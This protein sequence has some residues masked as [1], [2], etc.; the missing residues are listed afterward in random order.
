MFRI[1]TTHEFTVN[2]NVNVN[3]SG[4]APLAEAVGVIID[5]MSYLEN[6]MAKSFANLI[7]EVRSAAQE[8]K[9]HRTDADAAEVIEDTDAVARDEANAAKIAELQA[10][11]D[12]GN[13][14]E[15]QEAAAVE[16]IANL[17]AAAGLFD[18]PPLSPTDPDEPTPPVPGV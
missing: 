10:R 14:S 5:T 12:A 16:A 1:S 7:E 18:A 13:L 6:Q 15:V 17:R 2:V 11:I 3:L 9:D 4:L 8:I